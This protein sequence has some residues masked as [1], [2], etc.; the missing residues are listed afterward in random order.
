MKNIQRIILTSFFFISTCAFVFLKSKKVH[1]LSLDKESYF[2]AKKQ[3]LGAIYR[4]DSCGTSKR[5]GV[6]INLNAFLMLL[7]KISLLI[8]L[9]DLVK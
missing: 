7:T 4:K 1:F 3:M 6:Q 2:Y 9:L 8:S 5:K